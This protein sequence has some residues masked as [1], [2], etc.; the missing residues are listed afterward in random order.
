MGLFTAEMVGRI[1]RNASPA[2]WAGFMIGLVLG[3]GTLQAATAQERLHLT[4]RLRECK[5]QATRWYNESQKLRDEIGRINHRVE[6]GAYIQTV[7]VII[8]HPPVARSEIEA[9]LSPYTESLLG[10]P[11]TTVKVAVAYHL[12]NGRVL[13]VGNKMYQVKVNALLLS[14]T[15]TLMIQLQPL[16]PAQ[17]T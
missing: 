13:V 9:A 14:P 3:A 8:A 16:A 5:L 2:G 11:L 10:L 4:A 17:T 15:T 6:Q 12:F 1:M 7:D